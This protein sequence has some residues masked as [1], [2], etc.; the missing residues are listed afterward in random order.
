MARKATSAVT[1]EHRKR[2][3]KL[4]A[5]EQVDAAILDANAG[6]VQVAVSVADTG[7]GHPARQKGLVL[8]EEVRKSHLDRG[9][10]V[11]RD[12]L[13]HERMHLSEALCPVGAHR[14]GGAVL[15]QA[16]PGRRLAAE[17]L[18]AARDASHE[19]RV[20]FAPRPRVRRPPPRPGTRQAT[21]AG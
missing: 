8:I 14:L 3:A 21:A 17:S 12:G 4:Q 19:W 18:Q 7:A 11:G 15:V 20:S 16:G 1:S 9:V 13:A 10:H 6:R 2:G 5:V